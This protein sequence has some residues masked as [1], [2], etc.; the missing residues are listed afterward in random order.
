MVVVE[1]VGPGRGGGI[2]A[3]LTRV[4]E[5][6][7]G[8]R[9]GE[10][11]KEA[12]TGAIVSHRSSVATALAAELWQPYHAAAAMVGRAAREGRTA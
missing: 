5:E 11:E 7:S 4:G 3:V 6:S 9:R 2:V 10:G 1:A 12:T 8:G